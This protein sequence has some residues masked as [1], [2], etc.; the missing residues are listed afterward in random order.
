MYLLL[1]TSHAALES[2]IDFSSNK[3]A[4]T[5]NYILITLPNYV[6]P[7]IFLETNPYNIPHCLSM[8]IMFSILYLL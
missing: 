7:N 4:Y 5:N 1:F 2:I 3:H 6:L 8:H